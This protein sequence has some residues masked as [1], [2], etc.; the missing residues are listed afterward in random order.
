MFIRP[1]RPAAPWS[2]HNYWGQYTTAATLPNRPGSDIQISSIELQE[3]D[4]AWVQDDGQL[5]VCTDPTSGAAVWEAIGTGGGGGGGEPDPNQPNWFDDFISDVGSSQTGDLDWRTIA[6][7]NLGGVFQNTTTEAEESPV[8]PGVISLQTGTSPGGRGGIYL[9]RPN[10]NNGGRTFAWVG[11]EG[12]SYIEW[13]FRLSALPAPGEEYF[14]L[15]GWDNNTGGG[16]GRDGVYFL[17]FSTGPW[18]LGARNLTAGGG[19]TLIPS[20]LAATTDWT[21]FRIDWD[22][23]IGAT[24]SAG[25]SP[26]ALSPLGVIPAGDPNIPAPTARMSPLAKIQKNSGNSVRSIFLDYA[27]FGLNFTTGR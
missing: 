9:G 11:A 22:P 6:N 23:A 12:T 26:G 5:Y 18:Q 14:A 16:A 19:T 25:P 10:A 24:F 4:V 13:L 27:K 17:L 8:R 20:T 3:G 7:G 15:L 1:Q 21:R 2:D